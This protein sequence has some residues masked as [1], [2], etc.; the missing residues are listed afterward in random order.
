MISLTSVRHHGADLLETVLRHVG[1]E[2]SIGD[3]QHGAVINGSAQ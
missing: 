1:N 3:S 2:V